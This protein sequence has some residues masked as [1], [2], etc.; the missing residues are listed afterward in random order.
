MIAPNEIKKTPLNSQKVPTPHKKKAGVFVFGEI[1]SKMHIV[2]PWVEGSFTADGTKAY[3]TPRGTVDEGEDARLAAIREVGEETGIWLDLTD[4]QLSNGMKCVYDRFNSKHVKL[5][6]ENCDCFYEGV[7]VDEWITQQEPEKNK[8]FFNGFTPTNRGN[9]AQI[10]MY[11]VKLKGMEN[12]RHKNILKNETDS[13]KKEIEEGKTSSELADNCKELPSFSQLLETLRTGIW[14]SSDNPALNGWLFDPNFAALEKNHLM[15]QV[16]RKSTSAIR[17]LL[18]KEQIPTEEL[19]E[20]IDDAEKNYH[21]ISD[22]TKQIDDE[23]SLDEIFHNTDIPNT[24]KENLGAMAKHMKSQ[25]L[26]G[27]VKGLKLDTK[28]HPLR[29]YQEGVDIMPCET[30]LKRMTDI[31][32]NDPDGPY[33]KAMFHTRINDRKPSRHYIGEGLSSVQIALKACHQVTGAQYHG[34]KHKIGDLCKTHQNQEQVR[35]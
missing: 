13:S 6:E 31:A 23:E 2:A 9:P 28:Q 11:A 1:E 15:Q 25:G 8:E 16:F 7:E 19:E 29:Y 30:Y 21:A 35:C 24:I 33:A 26:I 12:L 34:I 4:E 32:S 17:E 14:R 20:I 27:D 5:K 18:K 22:G 3:T 10:T